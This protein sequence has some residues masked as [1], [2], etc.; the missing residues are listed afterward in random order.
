MDWLVYFAWQMSTI[1]TLQVRLSLSCQSYYFQTDIAAVVP[2]GSTCYA[3]M[4]FVLITFM[5]EPRVLASGARNGSVQCNDS[6]RVPKTQN[7]MVAKF[8]PKRLCFEE[9]IIN[10]HTCSWLLHT[11]NP[12][13]E[14]P[15]AICEKYLNM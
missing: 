5:A 9:D 11:F 8:F 12:N 3:N 10:L 15:H 6:T 14:K 2:L 7:L 1:F 4:C 13:G